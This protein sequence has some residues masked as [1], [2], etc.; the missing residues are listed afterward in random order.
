MP[1]YL[2]DE[3]VVTLK[4]VAGYPANK[5]RGLP[6][7]TGLIVVNDAETGL[8]VAIMDGAEITAARTGGGER[9]LRPPLRPR[10]LGP[11]GDP[12]LRRAGP[13]PRAAPARPQPGRRDPRLG[14]H[15]ERIERLGGLAAPAR[16][17]RRLSRA[18]R[19]S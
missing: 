7:I 19:S 15:P 2:R 8:P 12:R 5:A 3:D 17:G 11:R 14:P 4:W 13:L 16:V 18:R 1:A 6:Y 9:R 10:G